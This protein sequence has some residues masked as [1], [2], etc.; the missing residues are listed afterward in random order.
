MSIDKDWTADCRVS[1]LLPVHVIWT[2]TVWLCET[3][4]RHKFEVLPI[5]VALLP[6]VAALHEMT[7]WRQW[8]STMFRTVALR[9][10]SHTCCT[11]FTVTLN[12]CCTQFTVTLNTCCTQFTV[13]LNTCCTQFT[14]TLNTCCTQFTV[15][16]NTCCT[17]FTVTLNTCSSNFPK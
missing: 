2:E 1:H 4:G 10:H 17:Q 3:C 9:L 5:S 7:N 8:R 13:T 15:T 11:Q 16:L 14:V 12:T 6:T